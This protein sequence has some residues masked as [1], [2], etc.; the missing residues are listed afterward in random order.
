MLKGACP[1]EAKDYIMEKFRQVEQ[2]Q[3][4]IM[5]RNN[6]LTR[7]TKCLVDNQKEFFM[8]GKGHLKPF[9]MKDAAEMLEEILEE[10]S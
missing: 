4:C 1:D 6:T 5:K 2:I 8:Y 9:K 3:G 7:L 10:R